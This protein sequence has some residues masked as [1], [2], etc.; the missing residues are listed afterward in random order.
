MLPL[1][2]V[3]GEACALLDMPRTVAIN[4]NAKVR[5]RLK[6]MDMQISWSRDG[7][8]GC[9]LMPEKRTGVCTICSGTAGNLSGPT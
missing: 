8:C 1:S 9:T 6:R 3:N 7:L 2:D 4:K 5:T